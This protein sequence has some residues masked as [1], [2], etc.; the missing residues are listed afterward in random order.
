[1]QTAGKPFAKPTMTQLIHKQFF[2][3]MEHPLVLC[4]R[5]NS[6]SSLSLYCLV[7]ACEH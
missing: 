5:L 2:K 3:V 4:A 6:M 7:L 1:M